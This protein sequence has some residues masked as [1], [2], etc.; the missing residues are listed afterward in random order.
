MITNRP[1]QTDQENKR[2]DKWPISGMKDGTSLQILVHIH[3][4]VPR[5]CP[6]MW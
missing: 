2:E 5:V 3:V 4:F 6:V 1:S